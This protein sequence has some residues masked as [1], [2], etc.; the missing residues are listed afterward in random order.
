ML[1]HFLRLSEKARPRES[2]PNA[3]GYRTFFAMTFFM[4]SDPACQSVRAVLVSE[5]PRAAASVL[6]KQ[7]HRRSP[8]VWW[9]L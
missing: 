2:C 6:M 3:P 4:V 8:L 7:M 9:D 5:S 1:P